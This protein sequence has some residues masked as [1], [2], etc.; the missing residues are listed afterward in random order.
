MSTGIDSLAFLLIAPSAA[1]K[2]MDAFLDDTF[3]GVHSL[4]A[5]DYFVL[6]PYFLMLTVLSFYGCHRFVTIWHYFKGLKNMP[7]Q[8][9][10]RLPG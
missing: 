6:I 8:P 4:A 1:E 7:K 2:L 3:A 10:A 9:P 5:F